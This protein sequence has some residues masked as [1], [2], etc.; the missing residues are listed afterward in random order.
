MNNGVFMLITF[1]VIL[2]FLPIPKIY[3]KLLQLTVIIKQMYLLLG[4]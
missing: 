4:G 2:F 1:W 3:Y